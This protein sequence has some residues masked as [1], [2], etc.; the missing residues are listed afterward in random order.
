[1]NSSMNTKRKGKKIFIGIAIVIF[2]FLLIALLQFL[3][4]KLMP[5]IF[6]L[7][8]IDY[9]QALGLF[10][11]SKLLF[12]R[13]FGKPGSGFGR[14]MRQRELDRSDLS[15]E[16]KERLREEWKRRFDSKCGF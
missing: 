13:G 8:T 11:L 6:G 4:N 7:K 15:E 5:E 1:M 12:G 10:I 2:F 9:W 3:W 16:E 14:K